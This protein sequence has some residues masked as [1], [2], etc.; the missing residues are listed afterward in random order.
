MYHCY[1]LFVAPYVLGRLHHCLHY[2]RTVAARLVAGLTNDSAT[3]DNSGQHPAHAN[4]ISIANLSATNERVS[5][6][7]PDLRRTSPTPRYARSPEFVLQARQLLRNLL[8]S[9]AALDS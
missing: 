3:S 7:A 9:L 1:D 8:Q 6:A 2:S 5:P 4:G